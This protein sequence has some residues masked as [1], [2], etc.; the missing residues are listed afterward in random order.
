MADDMKSRKRRKAGVPPPGSAPDA[1][2]V[3][4]N[5]F[6]DLWQ[7]NLL[8]WASDPKLSPALPPPLTTPPLKA[9]PDD[10]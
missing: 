2:Q 10:R 8:A 5:D 6:L 4:A 3:L 9:P 7:E 1:L